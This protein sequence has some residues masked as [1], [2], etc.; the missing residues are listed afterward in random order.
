MYAKVVF[1]IDNSSHLH[2]VY[3]K[4]AFIK[5]RF[6][7]YL[8]DVFLYS[9]LNHVTR[10]LVYLNVNFLYFV[11]LQFNS[12]IQTPFHDSTPLH[13]TPL[14]SAFYPMS[15]IRSLW[16]SVNRGLTLVRLKKIWLVNRD[17]V[18]YLRILKYNCVDY[19]IKK[20]TRL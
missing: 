10:S 4:I 14:H 5:Q 2:S 1:K 6:F 17:Q 15:V 13:S 18:G 12:T 19:I 20:Y 11:L 3:S 9:G 7:I 8:N 16:D